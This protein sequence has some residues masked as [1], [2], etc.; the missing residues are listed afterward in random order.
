MTDTLRVET[1]LTLEDWEALQAGTRRRYRRAVT[2]VARW[3]GV[4]PAAAIALVFTLTLLSSD[5]VAPAWRVAVF[6]L[7]W[8]VVQSIVP[9]VYARATRPDR[10][11]AFVGPSTY[12][13][14]PE[15][16]HIARAGVS[17]SFAWEKVRDIE[18]IR[19]TL[20]LWTDRYS[21]LAIPLRDPPSG[22]T[23]QELEAAIRG[24]SGAR[25]SPVAAS[26]P[27]APTSAVTPTSPVAPTSP[28]AS[29]APPRG[30]F[31]SLLR[32]LTLRPDAGVSGL[33]GDLWLSGFALAAL[34]LWIG[35]DRYRAG[36]GAEVDILAY[37]IIALYA[38]LVLALAFV[39]SRCTRPVLEYRNAL[40][41]LIA[42]LPVLIL[43]AFAILIRLEGR[44]ALAACLLVCLYALAYLARALRVLTG[45]WQIRA[46]LLTGVLVCAFY[47]LSQMHELSPWLWSP[48]SSAEDQEDSDMSS[49]VAESLLF[50]ERDE[51][52]EAVDNMGPV[53][54]NAPAVYFVGFAGVAEQRVFAEEIKLAARVVDERFATSDRQVLLIND[55]RDLDTY[56]IATA[57]GLAYALR[58]VADKMRPEHDILFLALSSH[59]SADP[60]LS[61]SNGGLQLEQLSVEDLETAVRE[62]GIKRRIIVISACYAGGFIDALKNPDTIVI[63]AAAADRT[64]FGCSDDR[65]MTYFG[66]AF[67]RDALPNAATL[68]A[69]FDKAKAAIAVRER[70]EHETPSEP[71]AFFGADLSAVLERNPM[72]VEPS[73]I[74]LKAE[75]RTRA[76]AGGALRLNSAW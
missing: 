30:G 57:S 36:P 70:A 20:I 39:L 44:I 34:A 38:F 59:G 73:G 13:F 55:R 65:D 46:L 37:P 11:S 45:E 56:P 32:L 28:E 26:S 4:V 31:G 19:S 29:T 72:R 25:T 16:V 1:Q 66:E 2:G 64:S 74:E 17:A 67:Y 75:L 48:A 43:A 71:Q 50:D 27:V 69:A 14:G 52:D 15:G 49:S 33:A 62:S 51:I 5:G 18:R 68:Q 42:A 47:P 40:L 7:V 21:G 6:L 63:A 41:V 76:A 9:R 10:D 8:I 24:F 61:V 22:M 60:T 58:A 54:G 35:L 3:I 23:A 53:M 12:E